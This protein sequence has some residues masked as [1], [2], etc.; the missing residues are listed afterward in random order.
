MCFAKKKYAVEQ[1][2]PVSLNKRI[3]FP[4]FYIIYHDIGLK[5]VTNWQDIDFF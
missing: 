4:N 2:N 5:C 1:R 3:C